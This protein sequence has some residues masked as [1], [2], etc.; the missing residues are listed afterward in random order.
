MAQAK[1]AAGGAST[2]AEEADR[3]RPP[4]PQEPAVN[5]E[6]LLNDILNTGVNGALIGG[7]ALGNMQMEYDTD[8]SLDV[9]IYMTSFIGVH[10]CTCACVTSSLLYRVANGLADGVAPSWVEA[11][12]NLLLMPMAKFGMG[13]VSYLCSV[14]LISFRDLEAIPFWQ[15]VALAIGLMSMSMTLGVAAMMGLAPTPPTPDTEL[16]ALRTLHNSAAPAGAW[17]LPSSQNDAVHP[18]GATT[19]AAKLEVLFAKMVRRVKIAFSPPWCA[20]RACISMSCKVAVLAQMSLRVTRGAR[21]DSLRGLRSI[22]VQEEVL[23][24]AP[25]AAPAVAAAAGGGGGGS[26]K[27]QQQQQQGSSGNGRAGKGG[28]SSKKPHPGAR[29][30]GEPAAAGRS[31]GSK[32][33]ASGGNAAAGSAGLRPATTAWPERRRRPSFN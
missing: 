14:V 12:A 22:L 30:D 18:G 8:K 19:D 28:G 31:G 29:S 9:A 25:L 26:G 7:F 23:E 20:A 13:C 17:S 27:R 24:H 6:R 32:S 3:P 11:N 21:D 33:R 16:E 1:T 2:Y 15:Y 4:Q 5:R 10:A